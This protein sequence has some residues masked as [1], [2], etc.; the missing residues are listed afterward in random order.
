MSLD[1]EHPPAVQAYRSISP[2]QTA[3]RLS[4]VGG[5]YSFAECLRMSTTIV[6][7]LEEVAS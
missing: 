5:G 3:S 4:R 2:T 7:N 6:R 1:T